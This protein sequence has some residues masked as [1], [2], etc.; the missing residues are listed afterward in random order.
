MLTAAGAGQTKANSQ[1]PPLDLPHE[2]QGPKYSSHDP[3]P[4]WG[5]HSQEVEPKSELELKPSTPIKNMINRMTT[6]TPTIH[7]YRYHFKVK[8]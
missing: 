3:L 6:T 4:S 1:E 7:V 8:T 5:A 2:E